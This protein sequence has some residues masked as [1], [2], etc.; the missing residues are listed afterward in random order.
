MMFKSL[1]ISSVIHLTL[2][3]SLIA[4]ACG[5]CL[6]RI[7]RSKALYISSSKRLT[8]R[9]HSSSHLKLAGLTAALPLSPM[10][11]KF[12]SITPDTPTKATPHVSSLPKTAKHSIVTPKTI[13]SV[14]LL[15]TTT[16]TLTPIQATAIATPIQPSS[17][18]HLPKTDVTLE[19]DTS[20]SK[21]TPSIHV[22]GV[23]LFS[24]PLPSMLPSP[25]A[26]FK[27][28][29]KIFRHPSSFSNHSFSNQP[30]AIRQNVPA[31]YAV[32]TA[33]REIEYTVKMR[34]AQLVCEWSQWWEKTSAQNIAM[35]SI[36]SA[37]CQLHEGIWRCIYDDIPSP[38]TAP[39]SVALQ[40]ALHALNATQ[41]SERIRFTLNAEGH[42]IIQREHSSTH[43]DTDSTPH[44]PDSSSSLAE[45]PAHHTSVEL[46]PE[47]PAT[48]DQHLN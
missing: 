17:T 2:V 47:T 6:L 16:A 13:K 5:F 10:T 22:Q 1:P 8:L 28:D 3:I 42:W 15:E 32:Q 30:L 45:T 20:I 24:A 11:D 19:K 26:E 34:E 31:S 27:P 40:H 44:S 38:A 35:Q 7:D 46:A 21:Q 25:S 4:H 37:R 18:A 9:V 33:Q 23:Q 48:I 41:A 29:S 12:A 14:T 39:D 36:H 43:I